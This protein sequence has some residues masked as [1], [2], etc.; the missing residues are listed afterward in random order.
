MIALTRREGE[1]VQFNP[2]F[3]ASRQTSAGGQQ[4][5]LFFLDGLGHF[6]KAHEFEAENDEAAIRISESWREGRR[7]EL[8]HL[9]RRLR[10][11]HINSD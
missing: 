6:E 3:R 4:Y 1:F 8:W 5:R 10:Q 11:W 2:N 9:H 7:M